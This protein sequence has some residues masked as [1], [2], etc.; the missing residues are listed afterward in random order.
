MRALLVIDF[1]NGFLQM[2]DFSQEKER[3][4]NIIKDFKRNEQPVIFMRHKDENEG[5][6]IT[7]GTEES[8]LDSDLKI[9]AD[10]V[11]EKSTP[12]AF[13]K[14]NLDDLLQS[15][16]VTHIFV[17]GFNTEYCP[18]FTAIAA[19]DRGYQVTFIEDATATVNDDS[20]YEFPG[21]DIRDF[22]GSVLNWSNVI[23]VLD[24]EEYVEEYA[25][26][27]LKS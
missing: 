26:E 3:V 25:E 12:S 4:Q 8:E 23:E 24:F 27:G 11:I 20:V 15:L 2:G 6:P 1:Q 19:Y 7:F 5:S 9:D 18:Q 21:L 16:G 10:Y 13:F 17:T 14:T 22:V